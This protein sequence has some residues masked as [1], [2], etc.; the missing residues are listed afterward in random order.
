MNKMNLKL[1]IIEING[2]IVSPGYT[3]DDFQKSAFF[4]GQD[5]IRV[6]RI[7]DTV[8]IEDN[9]YVVSFFFRN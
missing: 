9:N 6:I 2:E 1:E 5:G 7:K 4:D 8:K 3:F